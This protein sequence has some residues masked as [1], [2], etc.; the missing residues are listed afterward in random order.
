MTHVTD[1]E[2]QRGQVSCPRSYSKSGISSYFQGS[3]LCVVYWVRCLGRYRRVPWYHETMNSLEEKGYDH[4]TNNNKAYFSF[5]VLFLL[6]L[7]QSLCNSIPILQMVNKNRALSWTVA[8]QAPLSGEVSRQ[9]YCRGLPFYSP[10]DLP[11]PG[12]EPRSVAL[13]A[14]SSSSEP[15]GKPK[16]VGESGEI[17]GNWGIWGRTRGCCVLGPPSQ[18]KKTIR[19]LDHSRLVLQNC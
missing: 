10:G 15:P 11:D 18:S 6:I 13:W 1:R 9:E 19:V 4:G 17:R 3:V 16:S 8:R 5:G 12:I 7:A 14:D 2:T